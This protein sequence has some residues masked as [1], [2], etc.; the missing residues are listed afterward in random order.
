MVGLA[1]DSAHHYFL[2]PSFTAAANVSYHRSCRYN[3]GERELTLAQFFTLMS[4]VAEDR[5]ASL[6]F[7]HYRS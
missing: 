2:S 5:L 6:V 3:R 7:V 4:L 1:V